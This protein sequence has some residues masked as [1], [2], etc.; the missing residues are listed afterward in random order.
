MSDT[1]IVLG[2]FMRTV[3]T[4][5]Q[6]LVD[7]NQKRGGISKPFHVETNLVSPHNFHLFF[8]QTGTSTGDTLHRGPKVG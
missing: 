4:V 6:F 8:H 3:Q 1:T 2:T 5:L 7:I